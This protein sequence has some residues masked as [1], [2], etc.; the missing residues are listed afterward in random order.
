M[1]D[2][3]IITSS[4][5]AGGQITP[6]TSGIPTTGSTQTAGAPV[7]GT[8]T[9][10]IPAAPAMANPTAAQPVN[11]PVNPPQTSAQQV[12]LPTLPALPSIPKAPVIKP[13]S[14]NLDDAAMM[15]GQNPLKPEDKY[16][17]PPLVKEKFPD[18]M[19]LIKETE[20]MNEEERDYWFQIL[21]IMTEE[22]IGKFR[23]I[24]L[25]EKQQLTQLD[26]EYSKELNKLND[27]HLLEWKEFESK[28]KRNAL[29]TA[30]A[31]AEIEEKA[32]EEDLLKRL[33]AT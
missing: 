28:E 1:T 27:K 20:S 32:A 12:T 10:A 9:V 13:G 14:I 7:V 18:L 11:P 5:G 23:T 26:Q 17:V 4:G 15:Q 2:D 25:N 31:Q 33:A 3:I 8:P 24:L 19:Q 29:S 21:P 6:P 22:Q 16:S 30:E